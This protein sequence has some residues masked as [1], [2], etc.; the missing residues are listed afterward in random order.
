MTISIDV[1]LTKRKVTPQRTIIRFEDCGTLY[2]Q[3]N[4]KKTNTI[5][6][7]GTFHLS[8]QL[9]HQPDFTQAVLAAERTQKG[10]LVAGCA[11]G[12]REIECNSPNW[13]SEW[14]R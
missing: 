10:C 13:T 2:G 4:K 14:G 9:K 3:R 1:L 8:P 7:R 6:G 12:L 11:T 5:P